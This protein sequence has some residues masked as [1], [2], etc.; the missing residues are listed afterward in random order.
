MTLRSDKTGQLLVIEN[1]V[2]AIK[3]ESQNDIV[4]VSAPD[5]TKAQHQEKPTKITN[6]IKP[7]VP[8][9]SPLQRS[10]ANLAQDKKN[11][12]GQSSPDRV[13]CSTMSQL[14]MSNRFDCL[15]NLTST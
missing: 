11:G 7:N 9:F 13:T 10:H 1:D 6:V 4:L 8:C 3:E 5:K 15:S 12:A 14:D 2:S